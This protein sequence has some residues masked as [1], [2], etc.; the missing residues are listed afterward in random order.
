[1]STIFFICLLILL[2]SCTFNKDNRLEYALRFAENNRTELEKVLD[3]YSTDPEKLAAARFL[4]VNMPYHYGYECWQQDTIKQILAD[5]V[6][7][8]SVYGEDL[9]IIDKKHLDKWSSYSHYYGEKIYE[10]KNRT[11]IAAVSFLI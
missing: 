3:Y 1:M 11:R 2:S 9:L 5:A 4:I 7:R 6:K 10:R 8:K